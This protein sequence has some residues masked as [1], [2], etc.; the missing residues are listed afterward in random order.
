MGLG[1]FLPIVFLD[2]IVI[3]I[4]FEFLLSVILGSDIWGCFEEKK[5]GIDGSGF[6]GLG[7]RN[8]FNLC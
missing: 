6:L 8:L 3:S 5:K 1:G 2:L 7:F 4:D